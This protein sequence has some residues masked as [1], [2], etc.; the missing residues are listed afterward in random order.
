MV[1]T[2]RRTLAIAL[3]ALCVASVVA[4]AADT[5]VSGTIQHVDPNKG[6]LTLHSEEG[7]T[8]E[9]QAPAALLAS[10]QAG[11]AVEVKVSGQ[12]A[13]QIHRLGG[14]IQQQRPDDMRRSE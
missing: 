2:L 5:T 10:L 13:T 3:A 6:H 4:L 1:H 7:K 12:K 14:A 8:M 11:D 9:L